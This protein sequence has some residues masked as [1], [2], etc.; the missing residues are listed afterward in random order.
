MT[1]LNSNLMLKSLS[2]IPVNLSILVYV[3]TQYESKLPDTLTE[4]YQ[5]YV[6]LKLS[7]YN[8]RQSDEY[9]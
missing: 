2:Y 5:H 7:L 9:M 8:Q 3:F 6:L 4:L 1:Q